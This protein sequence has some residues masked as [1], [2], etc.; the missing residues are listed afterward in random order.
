MN[1]LLTYG[2][3]TV[4]FVCRVMPNVMQYLPETKQRRNG[5]SIIVDECMMSR[6]M[7]WENMYTNNTERHNITIKFSKIEGPE[8]QPKNTNTKKTCMSLSRFNRR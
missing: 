5:I 6:V 8:C 1:R 3:I 4:V 2:A 7:L